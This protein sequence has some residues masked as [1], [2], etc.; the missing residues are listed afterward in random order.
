MQT[1]LTDVTNLETK[2]QTPT[3]ILFDS[4]SERTYISEEL[5]KKL[6]LKPLKS[7]TLTVMTFGSTTPININSS[8]VEIGIKQKNG[9]IFNIK[10]NVIPKITGKIQRS[11]IGVIQGKKIQSERTELG[12]TL[13]NKTEVSNLELLIGNDY[14]S[15]LISCRKKQIAPGLYLLESVLGWILSG[16]IQSG[17]VNQSF[18]SMMTINDL[19]AE[20]C[21]FSN[22]DTEVEDFWKLE[23]IGISDF[24]TCS[25]DERAVQSFNSTIKYTG[26]RYEVTWPWKE[27]HPNLP[28]NYQ[29]A[30]GRL[31]T[32]VRR[33]QQ[34]PEELRKYDTIIRGQMEKGIVE[35]LN[36]ETETG[37]IQHYIP[38]HA[39]I[40]PDKTTTKMRIVYDASA[41]QN[42]GSASLNECLYRGPILLED[43]CSLL[44]RFRTNK[45]AIL[46]DIE[47]AFLQVGL[48]QGER[49]VTRFLWLKN[50]ENPPTDDNIEVMRFTRVPFGVISS[51]FLLASTINHHLT[52]K[53]T[54]NARKI[55]S[56]LYVDN[57]ITGTET[58]EEATNL[59][60]EAKRIFGEMAMNLREWGSNSEQ[61]IKSVRDEDKMEGYKTKVL[62]IQWDMID[63]NM[64]INHSNKTNETTTTKRKILKTIAQIFDPLG[65]LSPVTLQAKL[66]LQEIWNKK[67]D[68]DEE[69][70]K[71]DQRK[72]VNILE[73]LNGISEI[74]IP[75]YI[76]KDDYELL[77]F[78]DASKYAYAT[79][80]YL[81]SNL[82]TNLV[83][84]KS[85]MA[86]KRHNGIPRLELL[87][88]VIGIRSL[89]FVET[90]MKL[91]N[92]S[93]TLWTDSQ[94]V[95]HWIRSK[96]QLSTFV[97]NRITEITAEENI[98]FRYVNTEDNPADIP[99]RG[100]TAL[101]LNR[102]KM[103]FH[104][105]AWLKTIK[106]E[107]PTCEIEIITEK[108]LQEIS[109]ETK[110][111][112]FLM[113][114][115]Q[116]AQLKGEDSHP[117]KSPFELQ[118]ENFSSFNKLVRLTA[119]LQ[120]F[121]KKLKKMSKEKGEINAEEINEG[122]LL[123]IIYIQREISSSLQ[124]GKD[125]NPLNLNL[126]KEGIIRCYGRLTSTDGTQ[127][128]I[129]P[130]ILPKNHHFTSLII[131][132]YHIKLMHAGVSHTLAELRQE[133][134]IPHGR[135]QVRKVLNNCVI[136]RRFNGGPFRLPNMSV[137]PKKKIS[138]SKPFT[139][140]GLDYMGPLFVK[141]EG[142]LK[143]VW[144]C[145]FTCITVRAVHLELVANLTAEQFLLAL[146]RFIARRGKPTEII[147][148][149]ATQFQAT[150]K[151]TE[152]AW[153]N[154]IK[155]P[156][157]KSYT[158]NEGITWRF[159][160]QLAPWMGGFYE[161]LIGI[162]KTALK[163]T[164]GK[165][166]LTR[167]EL[168]TIITETEAI[169]NSR[170]LVYVG[171]DFDS[172]L[173]ITSDFITMNSSTGTPRINIETDEDYNN[174]RTAA[175][176][177]VQF[178]KKGKNHLDH[179]WVGFPS[180]FAIENAMKTR[181]ENLVQRL[182]DNPERKNANHHQESPSTITQT[183]KNKRYCY[184]KRKFR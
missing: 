44:F 56:Q 40:T 24:S 65:Y 73:N 89:K 124:Q 31:K 132:H 111:S 119:W 55:M 11:S 176:N 149:N 137:W 183:T 80:I 126:D 3:R 90:G 140:T 67:L 87:A 86:P 135:N 94:C 101:E 148:D 108:I 114:I 58:E 5:A 49:D 25:E 160:V 41:K 48:Q 150:Q 2:K 18:L 79:V 175:N 171:E 153:R 99:T 74:K 78:C 51:P 115:S 98:S 134:W 46:A 127:T 133:F 68:W 13:P 145:L 10:A 96:R 178:W 158:A 95:L 147:L 125:E 28:D 61:F 136:C 118:L 36:N 143:K 163:K 116:V 174:R 60:R 156:D 166:T 179:L 7:E 14:Y 162:T 88:V 19:S 122:K 16:R 139:F 81:K 120:R 43:M 26:R 168:T 107:W 38:H 159:I 157:V 6:Q 170:P 42:R 184:T 110:G 84:A 17:E 181:V 103:W 93:K 64:Y 62:G 30:K 131:K 106:Q 33:L 173:A 72:W 129:D 164:L 128:I 70:E 47:K 66:L 146:R 29:L 169:I 113:E 69:I 8:S 20:P 83:F 59:Y 53:G 75:R 167:E 4:G 57:L 92:I 144:V 27:E 12:D 109:K 52:A 39:V 138:R 50:W 165:L 117:V 15:D 85:R 22:V 177:L 97:Q 180:F 152:K 112:K 121:V 63:D 37:L 9:E 104:G 155:D 123:W 141:E 32:N 172:G 182:P 54:D 71:E 34:N 154:T 21:I 1:A 130:I 151:T 45:I 161:R 91:K 35:K 77:C 102:S 142:T 82:G 105:P 23:T 100:M 76:E